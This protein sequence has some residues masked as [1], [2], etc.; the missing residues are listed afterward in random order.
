MIA[1]ALVIG[2][3]PNS[4]GAENLTNSISEFEFNNALAQSIES[5]V[6]DVKLHLVYRDDYAKLPKEI[7]ALNVGFIISL[8]CNA[9]NT[10]VTGSE[11]LYYHKSMLGK[12]MAELLQNQFSEALGLRDRGI[13]PID[14]EAKGGYLLAYTK[15]PC[16]IAEPFFI[17][18]DSDC[19]L[20]AKK[21]ENLVLAYSRFIQNFAKELD[22]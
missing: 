12:R 6:K 11:V 14:A 17:D 7:N 2:H 10:K 22:V 19:L 5:E 9:Y 1:C 21:R 4:T 18:N 8:H 15:A 16:V 13:K 20:V 3:S